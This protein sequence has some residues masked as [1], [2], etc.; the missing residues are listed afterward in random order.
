LTSVGYIHQT[1]VW[2][3]SSDA[4][5]ELAIWELDLALRLEGAVVRL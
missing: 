4:T 1:V 3:I 2:C 5:H